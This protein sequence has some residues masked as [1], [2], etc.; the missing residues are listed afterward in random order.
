M[1]KCERANA[2]LDA[3][4][5]SATH[6]RFLVETPVQIQGGAP[7]DHQPARK[8]SAERDRNVLKWCFLT[9]AFS[10]NPAG[11]GSHRGK[12]NAR[13]EKTPLSVAERP[14]IWRMLHFPERTVC[15]PS[16]VRS[17][18][19]AKSLPHLTLEHFE[20]VPFLFL[21]PGHV[22]VGDGAYS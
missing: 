13:W 22:V 9:Y 8:T 12:R 5:N 16:P 17:R 7:S 18:S 21:R 19:R 11:V 2:V 6:Q 14:M 10:S 3:V 15:L 1:T 20:N 4:C